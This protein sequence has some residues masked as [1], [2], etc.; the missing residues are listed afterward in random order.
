[1]MLKE[2]TMKGLFLSFIWLISQHGLHCNG[3][4]ARSHPTWLNNFHIVILHTND[5]DSMIER[6]DNDGNECTQEQADAGEC[7]GGFAR[8]K[9][10]VSG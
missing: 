6:F 1:M 3:E 4:P 10:M 9:T 7:Y 5:V 2:N 8:I